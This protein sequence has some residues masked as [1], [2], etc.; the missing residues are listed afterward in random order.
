MPP[1]PVPPPPPPAP[2]PPPP[3]S[4]PRPL[5]L[6]GPPQVSLVVANIQDAGN[7]P[8][9]LRAATNGSSALEVEFVA[10]VMLS[11]GGTAGRYILEDLGFPL[12]PADPMGSN[13]P[14]LFPTGFQTTVGWQFSPAGFQVHSPP[15]PSLFPPSRPPQALFFFAATPLNP[16][17]TP[18]LV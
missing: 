16:I 8:V 4:S 7:Y 6:L 15:P 11:T 14:Q 5:A 2:A 18:N 17:T 3:R 12:G 10:H 1:P 9:K 13:Y